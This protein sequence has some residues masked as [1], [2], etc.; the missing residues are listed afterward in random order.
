MLLKDIFHLAAELMSFI[1]CSYLGLWQPLCAAE[2]NHL[3]DFGKRHHKEQFCKIILNF[4]GSREILFKDI[5]YLE[6][7]QSVLFSKAEPPFV[8]FW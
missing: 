7:W 5:S 8:Q 1:K 2:Q 6:L 4:D 3:C